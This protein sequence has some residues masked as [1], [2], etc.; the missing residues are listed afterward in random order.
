MLY[1]VCSHGGELLHRVY[2]VICYRLCYTPCVVS[3]VIFIRPSVICYRLCYT[4]CVVK[5]GVSSHQIII[6]YGVIRC[7]QSGGALGL[8]SF[9]FLL[10]K[11]KGEV[12]NLHQMVETLTKSSVESSRIFT[13]G[14]ELPSRPL[15]FNKYE[16][17]QMLESLRRT[18][19]K[20]PSMSGRTSTVWYVRRCV[21]RWICLM[22]S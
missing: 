13:R 11:L 6:I 7:V 1:A 9:A 19:L 22:T 15:S 5:G 14:H 20:A 12:R 8:N 3:W 4:S 16:V 10:P 2:S 18:Q 21:G 17:L